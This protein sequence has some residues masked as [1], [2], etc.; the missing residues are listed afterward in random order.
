MLFFFRTRRPEWP[1]SGKLILWIV[2]WAIMGIKPGVSQQT[3]AP[4]SDEVI[5][6]PNRRWT[7]IAA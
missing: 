3:A 5:Q 7:G 1:I 6:L 4:R 2:F